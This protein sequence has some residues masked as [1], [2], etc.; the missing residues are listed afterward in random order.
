[1]APV[2]DRTALRPTGALLLNAAAWGLCWWPFRWLAEHGLHPLWATVVIYGWVVLAMTLWR[3]RIW[4]DLW[5][6]PQLVWIVLAAGTTNAAFNWA[7]T[8]GEVLR[9]V[10]LFYLM[11]LWAVLLARWLLREPLTPLALLRLAL[12]L[13][14]AMVVLSPSDAQA[15]PVPR[16]LSDWLGVLGGFSFALNN[17][18]LRREAQQSPESRLL[19]MFAGGLIVSAA[20]ALW[21]G[22]GAGVG[23]PWLTWTQWALPCVGLAVLAWLSNQALQYGAARVTANATA[24]I[25]VAEVVFAGASAVALGVQALSPALWVGGALILSASVLA[26]WR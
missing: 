11:P 24:V 16:S 23:N 21:A 6:R 2:L 17:V 4:R 5:G 1:M 20:V 15:W 9:V 25:M 19:A 22:P 3:P 26:A 8:I 10:L 18:L 12:A 13:C 7:V 14:G